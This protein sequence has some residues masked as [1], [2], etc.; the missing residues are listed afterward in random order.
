MF[1]SN[2]YCLVCILFFVSNSFAQDLSGNWTGIFRSNGPSGTLEMNFSQTN[3]AWNDDIEIK[4]EDKSLKNALS[5]I[6]L[7][8]DSIQFSAELDDSQ[9]KFSGTL[10]AVK[11]L[12]TFEVF[13]KGQRELVGV[14][15]VS[16]D[17]QTPCTPNDL[18][19]MPTVQTA[20]QRA[21]EDYD[22]KIANPAYTKNNPKVLFDEAHRN[23]HK[24]TGL[25]KPFADLIANDGYSVTP[26]NEKFTAD[27]LKNYDILVISNAR[28]SS[29]NESAFT[30]AECDAVV[31]WVKKG[32]SLLLIADHAPMGG[33]AE[34]LSNRFGVEMSKGYTDDPQNR[35]KDLNDLL[36]SRENKLLGVHAIT[37]GRNP[38]EKINRIVSF[39]G[40]SLSIPKDAVAI[41]KLAD[42]AYDEFPNSDK[43]NPAKNRAQM[44]AMKFGKGKVVIS[45]EA[46]ML[47]AQIA[48]NGEKFGMNAGKNIDNRQF[49]LNIMHWLSGL[50]K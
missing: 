43:K 42:T 24:T 10:Q 27:V 28:G 40:Q 47:T 29:E 46:A 8:G 20:A 7:S 50:L 1:K 18:P 33:W 6:R 32:G 22:T 35:D 4:F 5:D 30:D 41:L 48:P 2:I 39:T 14:F 36:F 31:E 34:K 19:V 21:D 11:L 38:N 12:G 15:C 16:K 45:G 17:K 49:A 23:L 44:V 9:V 26:N 3:G 13:T 37:T 25:Y